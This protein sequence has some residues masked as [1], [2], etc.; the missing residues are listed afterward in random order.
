[1][2][3]KEIFLSCIIVALCVFVAF[4]IEEDKEYF[5]YGIPT[6][7]TPFGSDID[8]RVSDEF[9][10]HQDQILFDPFN[11]KIAIDCGSNERI[12]I[13]N[14]EGSSTATVIKNID[15]YIER[16]GEEKWKTEL[17]EMYS[18][19]PYEVLDSKVIEYDGAAAILYVSAAELISESPGVEVIVTT[20]CN[21]GGSSCLSWFPR[22]HIFGSR[23]ADGPLLTE[24]IAGYFERVVDKDFWGNSL[25]KPGIL[26]ADSYDVSAPYCYP[27]K[28]I[29][30]RYQRSGDRSKRWTTGHWD[31]WDSNWDLWHKHWYAD[32]R[33]KDQ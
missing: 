4:S 16:H 28:Y 23:Q 1:M 26:I 31:I 25:K 20:Y 5:E 30:A 13:V 9:R 17:D 18:W 11:S 8:L 22:T 19:P 24:S 33:S 27:E 10:K 7:L 12:Q 3:T 6:A 2:N 15:A 29:V 14:G 21:L 32:R